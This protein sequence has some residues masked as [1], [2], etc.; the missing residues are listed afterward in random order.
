MT[1]TIHQCGSS[2]TP[3]AG[4][5]PIYPITNPAEEVRQ[6]ETM[7]LDPE[8]R[9]R[10]AQYARLVAGQVTPGGEAPPDYRG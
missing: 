4:A 3:S 2:S 9:A 6:E 5:G 1:D 7:L 10:A 8:E